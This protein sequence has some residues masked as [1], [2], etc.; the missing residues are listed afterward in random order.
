MASVE[1]D[2][3]LPEEVTRSLESFHDALGK[4]DDAFKPL[5]ETSMDDI[6]EQAS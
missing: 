1:A 4:V 6:K 5:L 2:P 3:D